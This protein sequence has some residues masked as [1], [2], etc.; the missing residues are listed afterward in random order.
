VD[1]NTYSLKQI[2]TQDRRYVIPGASSVDWMSAFV[3]DVLIVTD[4]ECTRVDARLTTV[5][6]IRHREEFREGQ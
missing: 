3:N 6:R 2:V 5:R 4:T 1:A